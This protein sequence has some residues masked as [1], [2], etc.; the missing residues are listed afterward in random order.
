MYPCRQPRKCGKKMIIALCI[1]RHQSYDFSKD[2]Y[3]RF[4]CA[5]Y[6]AVARGGSGGSNDPPSRRIALS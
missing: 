3:G 6:G 2:L 4:S 1:P 5:G